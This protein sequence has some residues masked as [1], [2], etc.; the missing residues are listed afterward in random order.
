[1]KTIIV[2]PVDMFYAAFVKSIVLH[3]YKPHFKIS[4]CGFIPDAIENRVCYNTMKDKSID[5]SHVYMVKK[6]ELQE[7]YSYPETDWEFI[8]QHEIIECCSHDSNFEEILKHK[9]SHQFVSAR[10]K[11]NS[12]ND[13]FEHSALIDFIYMRDSNESLH[14]NH[15]GILQHCSKAA[16]IRTMDDN[17]I[18][19]FQNHKDVGKQPSQESED[20]YLLGHHTIFSRV[21][22][23]TK[24]IMIAKQ[25]ANSVTRSFL[26]AI[27]IDSYKKYKTVV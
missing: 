22:H 24:N 18:H 1:M 27:H 6:N 11:K 21:W 14:N 7:N 2:A 23:E 13:F 8:M 20:E 16:V 9:Q 17:K 26:N 3:A 19:V 12:Y 5:V 10:L 4:V 15:T 25:F